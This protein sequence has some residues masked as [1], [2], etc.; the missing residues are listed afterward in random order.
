MVCS[1]ALVSYICLI[2]TISL[3]LLVVEKIGNCEGDEKLNAMSGREVPKMAS[4]KGNCCGKIAFYGWF[5]E[6]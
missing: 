6:W 3:C 2:S 1:A 4:G 5:I